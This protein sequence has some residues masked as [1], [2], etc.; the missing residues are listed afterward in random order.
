MQIAPGLFVSAGV[1]R[2][3]VSFI[4][5]CVQPADCLR[6]DMQ[7]HSDVHCHLRLQSKP[8]PNDYGRQYQLS[9]QGAPVS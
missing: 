3:L 6:A 7:I 4:I 5:R 9:P 8:K 2:D 1:E